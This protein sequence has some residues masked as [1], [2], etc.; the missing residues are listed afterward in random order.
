[1][2]CMKGKQT[3]R[4]FNPLQGHLYFTAILTHFQVHSINAWHTIW[5]VQYMLNDILHNLEEYTKGYLVCVWV[6]CVLENEG[7]SE[8]YTS[9]THFQVGSFNSTTQYVKY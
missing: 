4:I 7:V 2:Y 6:L 3:Y 1:M 9:L 5:V 8:C